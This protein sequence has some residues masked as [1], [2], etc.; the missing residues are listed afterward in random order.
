MVLSQTT[1]PQTCWV[2]GCF[3]SSSRSLQPED[4]PPITLS[5]KASSS[6]E[7]Q[8]KHHLLL[9]AS[10]GKRSQKVPLPC[11]EPIELYFF[12][13]LG[14]S[15]KLPHQGLG[16]GGRPEPASTGSQNGFC[17]SLPKM[18]H[19][20]LDMGHGGDIYTTGIDQCHDRVSHS[21]AHPSLGQ[22]P[23]P[24]I[25]SVRSVFLPPTPEHLAQHFAQGGRKLTARESAS[26]NAA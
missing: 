11:P 9:S 8:T 26:G 12:H 5:G 2:W 24:Q 13:Y 25:S 3:P 1:G 6:L 4:L 14:V 17:T 15:F 23:H 18:S 7:A 20:D 10:P 16:L 22:L 19:W 21:P